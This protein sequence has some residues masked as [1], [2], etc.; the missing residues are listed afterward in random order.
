MSWK[1]LRNVVIPWMA[2]LESLLQ[3][4]PLPTFTGDMLWVATDYSFDNSKSDFQTVGLLLADPA[5]MGDWYQQRN[6]VRQR[7]LRDL[8]SMSWK[9]LPGDKQREAAFF[10]FLEAASQ[11]NGLAI[12]LAYH[13]DS[14]FQLPAEG[15]TRF[16]ETLGLTAN[17]KP[18]TFEN[19]FRVAS[20]TALLVAGLSNPGQAIHWLSDE[21]PVFANASIESDTTR[22]FNALLR[23]FQPHPIG[24]VRYNT[25]KDGAE[26]LLQEDLVA[27]P[28][29]MCGATCEVI[30]AIKR[31]Y[32]DLP[33]V[34]LKL[35]GISERAQAF[36]N[37]YASD[38][39]KL[40]RYICTFEGRGEEPSRVWVLPPS[41]L[42]T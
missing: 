19:M 42:S 16:R 6:A 13:R 27:V 39:L 29:L 7:Y 20:C 14:A 4:V 34:A 33:E 30:T 21:D 38:S 12:T 9:K 25:T 18:Q 36:L 5:S 23:L 22:L 37:W 28:D 3:Q 1:P 15:A 8:R 41:L 40:K 31:E 17:W 10:P 2:S 26:Q 11:I 32:V 24:E 35:P